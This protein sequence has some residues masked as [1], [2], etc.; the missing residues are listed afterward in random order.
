[1]SRRIK[2]ATIFLVLVAALAAVVWYTRWREPLPTAGFQGPPGAGGPVAMPPGGGKAG[3]WGGGGKGGGMPV[4]VRTAVAQSGS[5]DVTLDVL[6]SVT[7]RN[8]VVVHARVDGLLER[9]R[10]KEGSEVRE[11]DVLADLDARPFQAALKQAEGQLAR[12]EALL[13]SA[14]V[15]LER[16]NTLLGQD[17]IAKQQVDDQAALVHQYEGVVLTDR[18]SVETARLNLSWT[19]ISAP[20]SGRVGLRQVDVGNMVHAA[21]TTG[22]VVLTQTQ[23]IN[24]TFAVPA[25]RAPQLVKKLRQGDLQSV[26]AYDRDGK[27]LLARGH[28][29][30][31]DNVVDPTTSTVK[32]KSIYDNRDGALLP[33][34]FV[35]ARVTLDRL[36]DQVLIPL[37]AVQHGTPGDYVYLVGPDRKVSV[38]VVTMGPQNADRVAIVKGLAVGDQ[39]VIDGTDKLHDGSKIEP[40]RDAPNP[41][42]ARGHG[43]WDGVVSAGSARA[44]SEKAGA[45]PTAAAH[46]AS[47]GAASAEPHWHREGANGAGGPPDE[48]AREA[49]RKRRAAERAQGATTP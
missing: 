20:I 25:E 34:Q 48:A 30:S 18:G 14:K 29:E 3:G 11:H 21:D 33:N 17:S 10:F 13:E 32:F 23:P 28:V 2:S 9:I 35:N 27:T 24:V 46:E 44:S 37:T 40:A 41:A 49:W 19:H 42:S 5:I 47:S 4:P 31:A 7:A 8:S 1:M 6:G 45:A 43:H 15:D 38:R 22:V 12:D 26:D 16:Y 39:V 36:N